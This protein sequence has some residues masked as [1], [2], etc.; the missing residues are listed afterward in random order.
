MPPLVFSI[1][2]IATIFFAL[3]RTFLRHCLQSLGDA[4]CCGI[5]QNSTAILIDLHCFLEASPVT[6]S[7]LALDCPASA[8]PSYLVQVL[9]PSISRCELGETYRIVVR[10]QQSSSRPHPGAYIVRSKRFC[11]GATK[12]HERNHY[13]QTQSTAHME[14]LHLCIIVIDH[15]FACEGCIS[16]MHGLENHIPILDIAYAG[17]HHCNGRMASLL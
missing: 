1:Y 16:C 8:M 11:H 4:K 12:D 3:Y 17:K 5:L 7:M 13:W 15:W 2:H 9:W 6:S 10:C 14:T